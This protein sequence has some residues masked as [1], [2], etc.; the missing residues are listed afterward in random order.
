MQGVGA[1]ETL[2]ETGP[3]SAYEN[4]SL[5]A[6]ADAEVLEVSRSGWCASASQEMVDSSVRECGRRSLGMCNV[7]RRLSPSLLTRADL[8]LLE[9]GDVISCTPTQVRF[10]L[11]NHQRVDVI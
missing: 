6:L 4:T 3:I 8:R 7:G 1:K 2:E 5:S 9:K 10:V 11:P